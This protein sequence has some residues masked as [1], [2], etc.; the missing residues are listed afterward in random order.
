M[1]GENCKTCWFD[2][3]GFCLAYRVNVDP[4]HICDTWTPKEGNELTH[5]DSGEQRYWDSP[6]YREK[7]SDKDRAD[8]AKKGIGY[9]MPD[10][11]YPTDDAEDVEKAVH[12][13]GRGG[14]DHDDI[15]KHIMAAA[16][17]L[18]CEDLIPDSWQPDGSVKEGNSRTVTASTEFK[19][20]GLV[21]NVYGT[22]TVDAEAI[23]D[24]MSWAV[25]GSTLDTAPDAPCRPKKPR[26][27]S[28]VP[29][30]EVRF[31]HSG[32]VEFRQDAATG[33]V[34]VTGCP[35]VY[36]TPYTVRD[37]FGEFT[38]RMNPSVGS[39]VE[40]FDVRLLENHEGLPYARTQPGNGKTPTMRLVHDPSRGLQMVATLD[41]N[42]QRVKDLVSALERGDVSE[43]SCG[44]IVSRDQWNDDFTER[45]IFQFAELLD[46]SI[47][48]YPA[49]P[50]TSVEV[51]RAQQL[52]RAVRAGKVLSADSLEHAKNAAKAIHGLL[53]AG[54]FD[55]ADLLEPESSEAEDGSDGNSGEGDGNAGGLENPDGSGVYRENDPGT[56]PMVQRA[57]PTPEDFGI[58]HG[59]ANLKADLAF[60]KAKQLHDPDNGTDPDDEDVLAALNEAEAAIDKAIVA[61]SKDAHDDKRAE[62]SDR[63]RRAR[64]RAAL[65]PS[66]NLAE[67]RSLAHKTSPSTDGK[68]PS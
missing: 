52:H 50:T 9:A 33:Q 2:D 28:I 31:Y 46:V 14:A 64:V 3:D 37:M 57:E 29:L 68:N 20:S 10:G 27:R 54:G 16:K 41:G 65:L 7:Y 13:V 21:V 40:A 59:L 61:Q 8:L 24:Q 67:V 17:R 4:Q 35:I 36:N 58:T 11:S 45:E 66:E 42:A 49:S 30:P 15:R 44:F 39:S 23:A 1:P 26:H 6:E 47:V 5:P 63:E 22:D 34:T 51:A 18:G 53:K 43:M 48:T 55:P 12:A 19:G 56:D 62:L 60:V 25:R 32:T 38:E